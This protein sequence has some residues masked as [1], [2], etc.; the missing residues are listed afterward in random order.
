MGKPWYHVIKLLQTP[1]KDNQ[2]QVD[3]MRETVRAGNPDS[4]Y[5]YR[6]VGE[7]AG[8]PGYW[9]SDTYPLYAGTPVSGNAHSCNKKRRASFEGCG[10][11]LVHTNVENSDWTAEST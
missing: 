8:T 4:I 9:T 7:K 11:E 6:T 10:C 1:I 2:V 3:N 5:L